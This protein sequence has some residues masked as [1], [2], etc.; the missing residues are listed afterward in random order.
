MIIGVG[1]YMPRIGLMEWK[2]CAI[3]I[4]EMWPL[5]V[6]FFVLKKKETVGIV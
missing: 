3:K 2:M 4:V 5:C 1:I 6:A